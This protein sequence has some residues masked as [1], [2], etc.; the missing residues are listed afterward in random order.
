MAIGKNMMHRLNQKLKVLCYHEVN[1]PRLFEKQLLWLSK[2]FNLIPI[3]TLDQVLNDQATLPPNPLL[4]TFDDAHHSVY[5]FGMP[6]LKRLNIS[7]TVFV[8]TELVGTESPYWWDIVHASFSPSMSAK[9][10]ANEIN[11]VKGLPDTDRKSYILELSHKTPKL[12]A[13]QLNWE[14]LRKMEANGISI[15]CHTHTHPMLDKCESSVVS[16]E[17]ETSMRLLKSHGMS[18][19][20]YFAYPNGNWNEATEAIL[21]EQQVKLAFLFD[22]KI[23]T[24]QVNPLRISRLSVGSNTSLSKLSLIMSGVHSKLLPLRKMLR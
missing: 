18:G 10:R 21:K 14:E 5:E 17:L 11:R 9:L 2:K 12:R 13:R 16:N 3:A 4:I 22:H 24:G 8:I 23:N 19:H 7:A 1:N 20:A 15:A 6:I